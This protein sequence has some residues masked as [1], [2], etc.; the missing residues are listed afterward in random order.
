MLRRPKHSKIE[1]VAP[2]EERREIIVVCSANQLK[3][4]T[5]R[6]EGKYSGLECLK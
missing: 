4:K 6:C 2:K 3:F 1:A 5:A